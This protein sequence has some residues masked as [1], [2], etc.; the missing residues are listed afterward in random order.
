MKIRGFFDI[1]K[2]KA[3]LIYIANIIYNS[4]LQ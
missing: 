3:E 1:I 4:F 2:K